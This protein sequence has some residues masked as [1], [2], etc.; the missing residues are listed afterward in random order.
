MAVT[1]VLH[2]INFYH[3]IQ[4]T[5]KYLHFFSHAHIIQRVVINMYTVVTPTTEIKFDLAYFGP[6]ITPKRLS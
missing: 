2:K 6:F 3:A 4:Y 1:F 5:T